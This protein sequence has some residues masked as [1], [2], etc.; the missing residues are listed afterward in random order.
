MDSG[1]LLELVSHY[2]A[3]LLLIFLVLAAVRAVVGDV[4]FWVELAF[5]LAVAVAYRPLVVRLGIGPSG[6]E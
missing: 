6:W 1:P 4:G 2:V 5:V 3:M